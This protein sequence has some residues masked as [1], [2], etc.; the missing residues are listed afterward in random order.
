MTHILG[1]L[2]LQWSPVFGW[3]L[4]ALFPDHCKK[5]II[6]SARNSTFDSQMLSTAQ[7]C[8]QFLR[9]SWMGATLKMQLHSPFLIMHL[10]AKWESWSSKNAHDHGGKAITQVGSKQLPYNPHYTNGQMS[11]WY[12]KC[13]YMARRVSVCNTG[14]VKSICYFILF[15]FL[16]PTTIQ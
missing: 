7:S 16:P 1:W 5:W 10:C 2:W 14:G 15:Y 9:C 11:K 6:H 13:S 4:L 3:H 12:L 8:L